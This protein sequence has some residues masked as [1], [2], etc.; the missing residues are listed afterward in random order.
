MAK[1]KTATKNDRQVTLS[2][3]YLTEDGD[4]FSS[5]DLKRYEVPQSKS[6]QVSTMK[7]GGQ[8]IPTP[9]NLAKL[10]SWLELSVAHSSCVRTKVQDSVG[11]GWKLVENADSKTNEKKKKADYDRLMTFFSKVN[12]E[13]DIIALSKKV[14]LDWEGCGN[15]CFEAVRGVSDQGDMAVKAMYHVNAVTVRMMKTKDR[16][17]QQ[18]GMKKAYFKKWGDDRILNKDTGNFV[19]KSAL[20][21]RGNSIIQIK[22]YTPKSEVYGLPEWLPAL[23]QMYGE[24][25]EKEYNLEFFAN[26]GIPAYAVVLEG[27]DADDEA[28]KAIQ[29]YF[30]TELKGD[31]HRTMVFTTPEGGKVKFEALSV[32]AKEASFRVYRRDNRDDILTA[33]HVPPYRASIVEKGA[34]GGSVARDVDKIYLDS[35]INPRQKEF[36]WVLNELIIKE[37][38]DID[39]WLF[40]FEDIDI[41]DRKTEAE[42]FLK[43]FQM[44]AMTPNDILKE[45][46]VEPY[47]GGD[48]YYVPSSYVPIGAKDGSKDKEDFPDEEEEA[49]TEDY[50]GVEGEEAPADE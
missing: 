26:H 44:G 45:L 19:K 36:T 32:Q 42:I 10:M 11:I 50:T 27:V 23:F 28:K 30:Q 14:M 8:T 46:G 40:E 29:K 25:K 22:Q 9:Y 38:F 16:W 18:I 35:V 20:K 2:K 24:M 7:W 41:A 6:H 5:E 1:K 21:S 17:I 13:E 15:G 31:P 3:M 34:L 39:S 4:L 37:G 33:H 47:R 49:N 12:D 48:T 43:Y